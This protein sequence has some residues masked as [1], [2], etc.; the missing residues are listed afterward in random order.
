MLGGVRVGAATL[1][2]CCRACDGSCQQWAWANSTCWVNVTGWAI[3]SPG[4]SFGT[5]PQPRTCAKILGELCAAARR[6]SAG[7]CLVC[8]GL[9]QNQLMLAN[10]SNRELDRYC[11]S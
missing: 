6:S 3:W 10:C 2:A 11:S 4:D 5:V 1:G 8:A 9:H 7:D